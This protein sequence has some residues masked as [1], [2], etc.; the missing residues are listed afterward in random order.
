M[1]HSSDAWIKEKEN[2]KRNLDENLKEIRTL[3]QQCSHYVEQ[4]E[5]LRKDVRKLVNY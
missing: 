4:L 2:M 3:N 1:S 5:K